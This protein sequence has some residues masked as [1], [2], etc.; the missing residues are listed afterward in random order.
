MKDGIDLP[1]EKRV[2]AGDVAIELK[3]QVGACR[4]AVKL[5]PLAHP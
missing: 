4:G 5:P 1:P 3:Q 2:D